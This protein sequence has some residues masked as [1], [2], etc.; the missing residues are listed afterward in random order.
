M[1]K[2]F[3]ERNNI[4]QFLFWKDPLCHYVEDGFECDKT[5]YR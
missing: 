4:I 1:L 5:G 2:S 3:K